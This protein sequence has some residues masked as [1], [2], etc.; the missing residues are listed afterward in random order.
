MGLMSLGLLPGI[1]FE[2]GSH[3]PL[4]QSAFL[5]KIALEAGQQ[6]VDEVVGLLER[7][8]PAII[9]MWGQEAG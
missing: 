3:H 4:A 7:E 8:Q 6:S 9:A 5:Q 1:V 2:A